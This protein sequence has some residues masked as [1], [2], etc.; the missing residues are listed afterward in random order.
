MNKDLDDIGIFTRVY[1]I[2]NH[3]DDD[4][5]ID[6]DAIEK[7]DGEQPAIGKGVVEL[8]RGVQEMGS[9][10]K[11]AKSM[12]MAYSK[13]W[14]LLGALEESL[15]IPLLNR[16]GAR[17]SELSEAGKALLD[18]YATIQEKTDIYA[19]KLMQEELDKAGLGK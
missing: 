8:L 14:G 3:I 1:I 15:K 11:A 19:R 9:L 16:D 18:I 2:S 6:K 17:G 10:N 12:G 7:G 5:P 4:S 13:A